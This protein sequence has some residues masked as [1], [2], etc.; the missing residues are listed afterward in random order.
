MKKKTANSPIHVQFAEYLHYCEFVRGMSPQTMSAKKWI[1][2]YFEEE[3]PISDLQLLTNK[4]INNWIAAQTARSVCGRTVNSRLCHLV[5]M[6]KWH[7]DMGL[8]MPELKLR[9]IVK[10]KEQPPRRVF[11]TREQIIQ[12]LRYADRMEWLLIKLCFD[13]GLRISELRN[14]RLTNLNG[15][16]IKFVG[17]GSKAR[18]S[19]MSVEARERLDDWICR[20]RIIDYLW[21]RDNINQNP[22]SVEEIRYTMRKPFYVA[23]L[24]DFYPHALRHSF[25][26]DIQ[27]NGAG[28]METKEML[29][30]S[31]AETTERYIHGLDGQLEP[32][33]GKY[34]DRQTEYVEEKPEHGD[35]GKMMEQLLRE[36]K[37]LQKAQTT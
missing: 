30:H 25:A 20:N 35:L 34:K 23:G 33:F 31:N 14:L 6:L 19:Y 21:V 5:A 24:R 15:R 4:H 28:L 37:N 8:N 11:Y 18:E 26:T 7:R 17:K 32:L 12:V 22:L 16:M 2:Q 27:R 10:L 3:V 36:M 13:C 1:L 29:G 9:L